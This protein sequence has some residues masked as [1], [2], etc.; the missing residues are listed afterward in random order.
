MWPGSDIQEFYDNPRAWV[1]TKDVLFFME[2]S[3]D[4]FVG[5]PVEAQVWATLAVAAALRQQ[6]LTVERMGVGRKGPT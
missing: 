4:L 6:A 5:N 3:L 2:K 1:K